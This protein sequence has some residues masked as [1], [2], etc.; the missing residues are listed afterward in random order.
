[1]LD[2]QVRW[3]GD[4]RSRSAAKLPRTRPSRS[5]PRSKP[6]K[7]SIPVTIDP[8]YAFGQYVGKNLKATV[9]R[10]TKSTTDDLDELLIRLHTNSKTNVNTNKTRITRSSFSENETK[11]MDEGDDDD[12]DDDRYA[13]EVEERLRKAEERETLVERLAISRRIKIYKRLTRKQRLRETISAQIANNRENAFDAIAEEGDYRTTRT[14]EGSTKENSGHDLPF[15]GDT[16]EEPSVVRKALRKLGEDIFSSSEEDDEFDDFDDD[17]DVFN[18]DGIARRGDGLV[19]MKKKK[20]RKKK[21]GPELSTASGS[22]AT[23]V[24]IAPTDEDFFHNYA[25]LD[26]GRM[27][28]QLGQLIKDEDICAEVTTHHLI[29]CIS[30]NLSGT[31]NH[32]RVGSDIPVH[33]SDAFLSSL[34]TDT[35]LTEQKSSEKT[36]QVKCI[37]RTNDSF[38]LETH[39]LMSQIEQEIQ[40][41]NL[42][43]TL[44]ID[45]KHDGLASNLREKSN[46]DDEYTDSRVKWISRRDDDD[47]D[48]N[49]RNDSKFSLTLDFT[50]FSGNEDEALLEYGIEFERCKIEN[51]LMMCYSFSRGKRNQF[52]SRNVREEAFCHFLNPGEAELLLCVCGLK[53]SSVVPSIIVSRLRQ[54]DV[55][56]LAKIIDEMTIYGVIEEFANF[57]HLS[58]R[59]RNIASHKHAKHIFESTCLMNT[60]PETPKRRKHDET[61]RG[62]EDINVL[63]RQLMQFTIRDALDVHL[64]HNLR[65][66]L[67]PMLHENIAEETKHAE[68]KKIEYSIFANRE[69]LRKMYQHDHNHRFLSPDISVPW[70][71]PRGLTRVI[72][73]LLVRCINF[74]MK[75]INHVID[76][77]AFFFNPWMTIRL[78]NNLSFITLLN[79]REDLLRQDEEENDESIVTDNSSVEDDPSVVEKD[80]SVIEEDEFVVEEEEEHSSI[81]PTRAE[82]AS[83]FST[84]ND[85]SSENDDDDH[86]DDDNDDERVS[87]M[88]MHFVRVPFTPEFASAMRT[89]MENYCMD[90]YHR[91]PVVLHCM[92]GCFLWN[93]STCTTEECIGADSLLGLHTW[94]YHMMRHISIHLIPELLVHNTLY[95][96]TSKSH[97]WRIDRNQLGDIVGNPYPVLWSDEEKMKLFARVHSV[98]KDS[99][100]LDGG[101]HYTYLLMLLAN[102][103]YFGNRGNYC[104]LIQHVCT[105]VVQMNL[106]L[107]PHILEC[108]SIHIEDAPPVDKTTLP[109]TEESGAGIRPVDRTIQYYEP[110]MCDNNDDD[111]VD[112]VGMGDDDDDD[113]DD[114]DGM[115]DEFVSSIGIFCPRPSTT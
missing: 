35:F 74:F 1:M 29:A 53:N 71:S 94:L 113:D 111:D 75:E 91:C 81:V 61:H 65:G 46:D 47:D 37:T 77:R 4:G 28:A 92:T 110:E 84:T 93:P 108:F 42:L 19:G 97:S 80:P 2:G 49:S 22:H 8:K 58:I 18:G 52:I 83:L 41:W 104:T 55:D 43:Y 107:F 31:D 40:T 15:L 76:A 66:G 21:D 7:R 44:S 78:C 9:E 70:Q 23:R 5:P 79:I 3:A 32:P 102:M 115:G 50:E 95:L 17:D 90:F 100:Y 96:E 16:H 13:M 30:N 69:T 14:E 60:S 26:D 86:D 63:M 105:F 112:D 56:R 34:T 85:S 36:K 98:Y 20:K 6:Q 54:N 106:M 39:A 10:V 38:L 73:V 48:E 62:T 25:N 51:V 33:F 24:N 12:D 82:I 64:E 87:S 27:Y 88:E 89:R 114:D 45:R 109:D 99:S 103:P 11:E 68:D 59:D 67:N 72:R 101:M 57:N